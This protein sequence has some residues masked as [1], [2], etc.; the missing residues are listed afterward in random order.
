VFIR[1]Y[2]TKNKKTN[3]DYITHRLVQSVKTEKGSRQR[4]IIN[5]GQLTLPKSQ[6]KKLAYALESKLIGQVC[7][8]ENESEI[9]RIATKAIEHNRL[10]QNVKEKEVAVKQNQKLINIDINSLKAKRNRTLGAEL[11]ASKAWQMLGFDEIFS[12]CSFNK[13]QL[14]LSKAVIIGRL[15][16]PG[17][18]LSTYK[19]FQNR[20]SLNELLAT[21]LSSVG[22]DMFYEI[23]DDILECKEKIEQELNGREKELFPGA[24]SIILYDL[25]NTYFEG[26]C[27]NNNLAAYGK[28]KSKRTDCPI[29]TLAL[30]VD[31]M[32]FPLFSQIYKGNQSEP[33]TLE[34]ILIKLHKSISGEQ[35]CLILPTIVM[36]RG[37]ATEDNI[38]LLKEKRYPYIVVERK[39]TENSYQD[40]FT[41]ARETFERIDAKRKS[42]YGD[43]N[44]VYVKKIEHSETVCRVLCLSE[45]KEKKE[46]AI[47]EK[48]ENLFFED[49]KKIN[50]TI[51]K[52]AIKN[53]D[54]ILQ[55]LGRIKERYSRIS[56]YYETIVEKNA[57]EKVTCISWKK[58][59]VVS[60]K[61][62]LLGCYVIETTHR[63]LD[64]KEIWKLY[65]TLTRVEAAFR[66]LKSELG[67][68]PVYHHGSERTEGHLFISVLAYHML[69]YIE[70]KLAEKGDH[71]MWMTVRDILSTHQRTTV[72]MTAEDGSNHHYTVSGEVE[73]EQ[74]KIYDI[75]NVKN[76]LKTKHEMARFTL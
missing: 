45:G 35:I 4:I 15:I 72:V 39:A 61:N 29:V 58:I 68:R 54:K 71:R 24:D 13:K 7:L 51:E 42:A 34:K 52:G 63:E 38:K 49:L 36:D 17:S 30:V 5:L 74:Q 76:Q 22:K 75:L 1:E 43:E 23:V 16:S 40:E 56:K 26:S 59:N 60:E 3:S 6:W 20:S 69:N 19:W 18:D 21:D 67:F 55:R 41:Q 73:N 46:K 65:M 48:K 53:Y 25:T 50:K 64:A 47:D 8:L 66:A 27:L 33:E 12:E 32:G 37:I 9:E 28:C 57:E 14:A 70:K 10:V 31:T 62:S 11:V 44:H 2:K